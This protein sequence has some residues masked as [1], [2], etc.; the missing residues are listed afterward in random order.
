MVRDNPYQMK[1]IAFSKGHRVANI[2]HLIQGGTKILD[3]Y[4]LTLSM[5][6]REGHSTQFISQSVSH[7]AMDLEDNAFQTMK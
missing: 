3:I 7:S 5:H 4:V 6:T 1:R 2:M